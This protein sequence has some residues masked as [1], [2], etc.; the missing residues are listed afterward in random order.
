MSDILDLARVFWVAGERGRV[1][2][3]GAQMPSLF[4]EVLSDFQDLEHGMKKV[5]AGQA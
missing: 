3:L 2:R 1:N 4:D 5:K